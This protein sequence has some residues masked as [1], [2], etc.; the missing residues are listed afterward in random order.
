MDLRDDMVT[1]TV[2]GKGYSVDGK[3]VASHTSLNSF[4][5]NQAMLT[6]TKYMC[7]EGGC[8][9]C[10]VGVQSTHPVTQKEEYYAVNS[11]LVPVLACHGM[12]I[13]TVEGIGSRQK[14]YHEIQKKL[15]TYNGSQCGY[16]SPGMVMNMYSL[17]KSNP[18]VMMEEVENS[19][20][21]NICRCT[22]YRPILDAFKSLA[23]D[24]PIPP[25][26]VDIDIEEAFSKCSTDGC[27][28]K[29]ADCPNRYTDSID[30][31]WEE[32]TFTEVALSP[33]R[34]VIQ[35][36]GTSTW[37]RV[38]SVKEIMELLDVI[39]DNSYS[40]IAGNT[41]QGVYRNQPSK[42]F[43]IDI[44]GVPELRTHSLTDSGLDLGANM[45]LTELISLFNEVAKEKPLLFG[46]TKVLA[47]HIDLVA[48]VPVRNIGT[49]AGNLSIKHQ[50]R[51]FVSDIFVLMETAG[52]VLTI[53]SLSGVVETISMLEYLNLDM[54]KKLIVKITLPPISSN[55]YIMKTYKILPRK[56]NVH[57][58]VNAGFL[59]RVM[60]PRVLVEERPKIIFG[61]INSQLVHANQA[62]VY[63]MGKELLKQDVLK[64]VMTVLSLELQPDKDD[65][66]NEA[67]PEYRKR[68]ASSLLYK[69]ILN[70]CSAKIDKRYLSGGELLIRPL[71]S[72]TQ[73]FDFSGKFKPA[74][75]PVQKLEALIQTAGEAEYVNDL[76]H[77][78]GELYGALVITNRGPTEL[79]RVDATK[80]LAMTGVVSFFSAQDIPGKNSFVTVIPPL[81]VEHEEIFCSGKVLY[82]GQPVGII[83]ATTQ[84]MA[85]KAA[86][87]VVLEYKNSTKPLLKIKEVLKSGD[88]SRIIPQSSIEPKKP[89]GTV[90][91]TVKGELELG[92]QYHFTMELH[93]CVAIPVDSGLKVYPASQWMQFTQSAIARMLNVPDNYIQMEVKRIGGGFG[94]KL[95]RSSLGSCACSLAA[96]LLNKPVRMMMSME[97]TMESIGKRCPS[98]VK[99]EAGVNAKGVLQYLEINMYDDLGQ[100]LNDAVWL[101][102]NDGIENA[103]DPST[104]KYNFFAVK[105]DNSPTAWMRAPG[106]LEAMTAIEHIMEHVAHASGITPIDVRLAN[107]S[108]DY[109]D[110]VNEIVN[111]LKKSSEFDNRMKQIENFNEENRWKKRGMAMTI[112]KYGIV[113]LPPYYATVSVYT[114]DGSVVITSGG[115]EM[116]QGVNTKAAQVCAYAL[117]IGLDMIKVNSSMGFL[118]PGNAPSGGSIT[119]D[120]V[121]AAVLNCCEKLNS[122]LAP[123]KEKM[124]NPTWLSLIQAAGQAGV[125]LVETHSTS[126]DDPI[127]QAYPVFGATA[128]EVE[129]DVLTG[130]YQILRVDI[131]EDAGESLNPSVDIG[132]IEGAFVMG[133]GYFG[134]EE[135]KYDPKTGYNITH[136]TWDYYPPGAKDIPIDFRVTLR[137]NAPNPLGVLRS[138]T[139][140]EPPICMAYSMPL[141][142]RQAV[143]SARKDA[144]LK[145]EWFSFNPP[146]TLFECALS[147]VRAQLDVD[148]SEIFFDFCIMCGIEPGID[149]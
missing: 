74:G 106:T 75:I 130:Q 29:C 59:F 67:S 51:D 10:V 46:Y 147:S 32:M 142:L 121:C 94:C 81:M 41:A 3:S 120:S 118:A 52:A 65:R 145:D 84:E 63:L 19:F 9:V 141:A 70:I 148:T 12:A 110:A 55:H 99:Y 79:A 57:A 2:N 53:C 22:G 27:K 60:N 21:G 56:Q 1:F 149:M 71:S 143:A 64:G 7:R 30:E 43:Y 95:S 66:K 33:R 85:I 45:T 132:Q 109:K 62:E 91:F 140:G 122:R 83:V 80:A 54:N 103:Y 24:A 69:F 76:P 135:L 96:F 58:V 35:V 44:K 101:F 36:D 11:C 72:G 26:H 14:G 88:A 127:P 131:L 119:S 77:N 5:R 111:T 40:Y 18:N 38:S 112:M 138:K 28:S 115:I 136:R 129:L 31:E 133:L 68:L 98:Y 114:G 61:G 13:V 123:L 42:A 100:S 47:K 126:T 125:Q 104:Y 50:H 17:L 90:D 116:G 39:G 102:M 86:D 20:G 16:C 37:Y 108:S 134:S 92:G 107:L 113:F 97:T 48:N 87:Q 23:K 78:F 93:S 124:T 105:T 144:G 15:A 4:L 25:K 89:P 6:G 49:I 146:C 139:T 128:T 34:L 117:G 82:A 8:G 137:K 73:V